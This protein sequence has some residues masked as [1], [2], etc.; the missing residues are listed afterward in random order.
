VAVSQPSS[1]LA[2]RVAVV[3]AGTTLFLA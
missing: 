2:A 3:S 1:A